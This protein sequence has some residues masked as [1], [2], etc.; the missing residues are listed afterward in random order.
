MVRL[1]DIQNGQVVPSEHCYTLSSLKRIMDEYGEE[2]VKVYAYLFYMT[3][4]NPDLNPFFDVP[5]QDKEELI[6]AEVDGDFSGEDESIRAALKVCQKMYETPTYRAYQGIKIALDNMATFMATE[7]PTS[8]RDG[9]ATALLRIA[10][11]FD[12]VRQSFKGVYRDLQ[13]E[14]QSSV[15]GGQRLAYDQ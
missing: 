14:Q 7:K 12:S 13:E 5:E 11:R 3:C 6:L 8:G 9:S 15:R 10:E 2:A 1:F 4:P